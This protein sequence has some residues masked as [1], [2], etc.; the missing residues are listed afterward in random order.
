MASLTAALVASL[1]CWLLIRGIV[2][3]LFGGSVER[4]SGWVRPK[5]PTRT[6][7]AMSELGEEIGYWRFA[8]V[9]LLVVLVPVCFGFTFLV[10]QGVLRAIF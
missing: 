6:E 5:H 1:A 2:R 8:R 9:A 10:V 3:L 4:A 7:V